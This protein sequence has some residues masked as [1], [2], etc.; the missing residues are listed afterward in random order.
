MGE[1]NLFLKSPFALSYQEAYER[2]KKEYKTKIESLEADIKKRI[3]GP[4]RERKNIDEFVDD[5]GAKE[6]LKDALDKSIKLGE[7][8]KLVTFHSQYMY[9]IHSFG[10]APR[11][12]ER[13]LPW[14]RVYLIKLEEM[15]NNVMKKE[16]PSKDFNIA[17]PYW[18]WEHT[19]KI[20]DWFQ[21]ITPRMDVEVYL[22]DENG[23]PTGTQIFNV[24]VERSPN[25]NLSNE[26]PNEDQVNQVKQRNTFVTFTERLEFGPHNAVHNLVGGTMGNPYIS[27]LDPLFFCHHANVDRIWAG[28]QKKQIDEGNTEFM[29][30]TLFGEDSEMRPWFPEYVEPQTRQI[31][32][33]GYTY[34]RL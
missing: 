6:T 8:S 17:F 3:K 30:P 22:Y 29:H 2:H 13:F 34:D 24:Q 12:N 18:N 4:L 32:A 5:Q 23:E 11:V 15:L 16:E 7:Y 14:H 31:E 20:P 21:D 9:D 28:W 10:G 26:L 25:P 27:P 33:M 19:R 1:N